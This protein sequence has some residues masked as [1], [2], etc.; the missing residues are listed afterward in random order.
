MAKFGEA[1]ALELAVAGADSVGVDGVAACKVAR[2]GKA[3]AGAEVAGEDG[4]LDLG[5]ELAVER[6]VAVGCEPEAHRGRG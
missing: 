5:D 4:E 6:D 3:L 1:F 2:A